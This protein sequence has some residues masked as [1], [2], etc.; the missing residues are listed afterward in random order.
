MI[1]RLLS[2]ALFALAPQLA[3]AATVAC[4]D[5]AGAVQVASCPAEEELR[6]TFSGYCSD[7]GKAYRG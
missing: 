7:Y 3:A 5:L 6:Y 1:R 4:P 2:L